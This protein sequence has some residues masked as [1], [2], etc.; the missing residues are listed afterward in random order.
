MLAAAADDKQLQAYLLCGWLAGLRLSEAYTLEWESTDQAPW[1]DF[2]R[3]RIIL[4]VVI[5]KCV[6]DQW[7]PLD[8]ALR[9][10][11]DALPRHATSKKVFRFSTCDGRLVTVSAISDRVAHLARHAGVRLTYHSLRKGFGC[12]YA[13]R[14]PAQ[15]LQRLMRHANIKTTMEFYANID[16]AVEEAVFGPKDNVPRNG[17]AEAHDPATAPDILTPVPASDLD[18][19]KVAN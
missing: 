8:P 13:G 14:V 12:R 15:V 16:V 4:P 1:V 19:G 6:E 3:N 7:A 17:T 10:A 5:V 9:V 18:Q 11:L 2:T